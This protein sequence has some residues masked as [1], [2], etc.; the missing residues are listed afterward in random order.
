MCD[1]FAVCSVRHSRRFLVKVHHP[2]SK[3]DVVLQSSS[4][5]ML[6]DVA[7]GLSLSSRSKLEPV[8]EVKGELL[9][10]SLSH[11]AQQETDL[12]MQIRLQQKSRL[13]LA[14]PT[15]SKSREPR[16]CPESIQDS[17]IDLGF[18]GW[19]RITRNSFCSLAQVSP[20]ACVDLNSLE[21]ICRMG[22]LG[23]F[24]TLSQLRC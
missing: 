5:W 11:F 6:E 8:I 1:L 9:P 4:E 2:G 22:A 3:F 14:L 20:K 17:K 19:V 21:E 16:L 13:R 10:M 18:E 23:N 24:F 15:R 7:F 12:S